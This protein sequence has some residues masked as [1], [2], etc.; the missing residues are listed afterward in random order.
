MASACAL[1]G[2]GARAATAAGHRGSG[3]DRRRPRA[4]RRRASTT[5]ATSEY[6]VPGSRETCVRVPMLGVSIGIELDRA[7][8]RST[9]GSTTTC[10]ITRTPLLAPLAGHGR[11]ARAIRRRASTICVIG[12]KVRL[13]SRRHVAPVVW[14]CDSA[15]KLPNA[16]NESGLGLDTTDF[17]SRCSSR[18]PCSPSASSATS[19][20]AFWAI[21]RA[22]IGRMTS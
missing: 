22:A 2:R 9:A 21:P 3:N 14:P 13:V 17:Y 16:S 20:S 1:P 15:T 7:K 10:R 5:R 8:C 11:R 12:T 19:A 18:R 6:P 4:R